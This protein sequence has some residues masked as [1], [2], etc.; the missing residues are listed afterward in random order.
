[1]KKI[2]LLLSFQF[3]S[4]ETNCANI[5]SLDKELKDYS[6]VDLNDELT[7]IIYDKENTKWIYTLENNGAFAGC[8]SVKATYSGEGTPSQIRSPGC[9]RL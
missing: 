1:M 5:D 3:L 6:V 4:I 9:C 2:L 7:S 8:Y